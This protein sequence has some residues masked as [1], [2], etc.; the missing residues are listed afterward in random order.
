[1]DKVELYTTESCIYCHAAKDFFK[2]HNISYIERN[3][4]KDK[5]ARKSLMMRGYRSVPLIVIG[6]HEILGFD[7]KELAQALKLS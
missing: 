1:M 7:E 5:E 3:I 2:Q 6:D 4:T